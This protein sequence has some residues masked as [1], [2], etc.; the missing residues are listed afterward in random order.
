ME[1]KSTS[2]QTGT[3]A[4][5]DVDIAETPE[6]TDTAIIAEPKKETAPDAIKPEDTNKEANE[7]EQ[8]AKEKKEK[9]EASE[10]VA[11]ETEQLKT[12][13]ANL[14]QR[15]Q[16]IKGLLEA[17]GGNIPA[18][19]KEVNQELKAIM[20]ADTFLS[21]ADK[22]DFTEESAAFRIPN[23]TTSLQLDGKTDFFGMS[24]KDQ[25]LL[26]DQIGLFK[27]IVVD[28]SKETPVEQGYRDVLKYEA[29]KDSSERTQPTRAFYKKPRLSGF[30]ESTYSL[31]ETQ[32][33]TNEAGIFNLGFGLSASYSNLFVSAAVKAS[34]S[35]GKEYQEEKA[36][37]RKKVAITSSFFLPKIELSFDTLYPCASD[38]FTGAVEAIFTLP[39]EEQFDRLIELLRHFGHFVA[40]SLVIGGRLYSTN[41]KQVESS[42]SMSNQLT[43]YSANFQASLFT[44]RF[45]GGIEGKM[46]KE[47][48]EKRASSDTH[49]RQNM[50]LRAVGGEGAYV[51]NM[52]QWVESLAKFNAWGLV[53][54][55]NLVTSLQ[56]L[57]ADLQLKC[58]NL[59]TEVVTSPSMSIETLIEKNAHFL[60]Y[61][62]YIEQYG[63]KASPRYF[64]LRNSGNSQKVLTVVNGNR[65]NEAE[66]ALKLYEDEVHQE[67]WRSPDGKIYSRNDRND[68]ERYVLSVAQGSSNENRLVITQEDYFPNQRWL[69]AGGFLKNEDTGIYVEINEKDELTFAPKTPTRNNRN[70][71]Q[72]LTEEQ[73]LRMREAR[74]RKDPQQTKG[75]L[76][77]L[78]S[79]GQ[80]IDKGQRL[81]SPESNA[82]LEIRANQLC[83]IHEA[84]PDAP[85]WTWSAGSDEAVTIER[86]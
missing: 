60:F 72:A 25:R 45:E 39:R 53:R 83:I 81:I 79:N 42:T 34:F 37:Q 54:F 23:V 44:A 66:V 58:H 51:N 59:L 69:L 18:M 61:Q 21:L 24:V 82:K 10:R 73:L 9:A 43:K 71:W 8:K 5:P 15:R 1:S 77:S 62:G 3:T 20:G 32:R 70:V 2:P 64:V 74:P 36:L 28:H 56:V 50:Q 22:L 31:D 76:V 38:D 16:L 19:F 27:G 7:E 65:F 6:T 48:S 80:Y 29:A 33:K 40:T 86:L 52:N 84:T 17:T 68:A 13:Q 47:D 4:T 30:F 14:E 78:L 57:P 55:D 75:K 11:T 67:W 26:Y 85:L 35:Y 41:E 12:R 63:S 46:D 49:E